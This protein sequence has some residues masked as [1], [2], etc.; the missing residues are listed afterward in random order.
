[1]GVTNFASF[2]ATNVSFEDC[3]AATAGGGDAYGGGVGVWGAEVTLVDARF[4][5][6]RARSASG[7]GTLTN[8]SVCPIAG[9]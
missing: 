9:S 7:R 8:A 2:E 6:T 1:M 5:R 4:I 3:E